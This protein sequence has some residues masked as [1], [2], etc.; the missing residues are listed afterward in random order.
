MHK[1]VF[2]AVLISAAIAALGEGTQTWRQTRFEDF[3][4]GTS[5]GVALRS[6][7]T[8]ELAPAL[9]PLYTTPS[10]F[11]WAIASDAQGNVYAAAGA[12]ARVYKIAPDGKAGVIFEPP[13]LQVQALVVDHQGA[14]YAATSPD[15]KI[16][17]LA[18]KVAP[19]AAAHP[20]AR[21]KAVA[22]AANPA[23][24]TA[25]GA[26]AQG[27][28]SSSVFFDPK[29]K[30]IWDLALDSDGRLYVATGDRGE[31]YRVEKT[32]QGSVFF[33][34]DE[35][36]IRVLKCDLKGNLIAGSD[37]S[38]LVYRISP[39]GEAFVLYSAPRKEITAL[40]I[41][42]KGNIY[43]AGVGEKRSAQPAGSSAT[44]SNASVATAVS[45]A[46]A[47]GPAGISLSSASAGAGGS[48]IY[49]I[50]PEGAPRRVWSGKEDL[51]YALTFDQRGRLLAGTGNRGHI[52]AIGLDD[53]FTDL[54]KL[55][56]SQVTGFARAP[57]GALYVATSN[58]GKIAL[59]EAG[60]LADG[61]FDSD[62]YDAHIFSRWGRA[63]VRGSGNFEFY[64]RSGN[65]DNPD[66]NWSPWT[67]VDLRKDAPL[68]VPNARFVQWRLVLHPGGSPPAIEEVTINYRPNNVAPEIDDVTVVVGARFQPPPRQPG[69]GT[70]MLVGPSSAAAASKPP[71]IPIPALRDRDSVAVRWN[72]HDDNDDQLLYSI[73]YRGDG[74]TKWKLLKDKLTDKF[75][76]WDA[77]LLP[78][79]GYTLRIVASDSPSHSPDESLS[80]DRESERFEIDHTPPRVDDLAVRWENGLAHITFRGVDTFSPIKRAEYSVDAGD[81]QFVEPVGQLSD[82]RLENYDFNVPMPLTQ[83]TAEPAVPRS[84]AAPAKGG[85]HGSAP[86]PPVTTEHVVVVRVY[87]RYDNMGTAKFVFRVP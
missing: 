56:A 37:G 86:Q 62:V 4:K 40:A 52:F 28:Y 72:A 65:V 79:G 27:E 77:G 67:K 51:V 71:D 59:L 29:T 73:Y 64:A 42:S 45:G 53:R 5:S 15:G 12:P 46:G 75:Y 78:D 8:L 68:G 7:G 22:P 54:A 60:P 49:M 84:E 39:A 6:D 26:Q 61:S 11:I 47:A 3:Q 82:S 10:S 85:D 80:S 25:E 31:I 17:R 44:P 58:L 69:E 55:S 14:I 76:S 66:R 34:S 50:T 19:P 1:R 38:G 63:E 9:R 36:H 33:K 48:E 23:P 24:A 13:E 83:A 30:Y 74:E 20:A 21:P 43:A 81:W 41:D 2:L 87:D 32:G 16:Y 18:P 35:A 70:P 57:D